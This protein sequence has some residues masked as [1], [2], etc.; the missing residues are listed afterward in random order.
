MKIEKK[1]GITHTWGTSVIT[2]MNKTRKQYPLS[3]VDTY[4]AE[5]N[6]ARL[7]QHELEILSL[8][9]QPLEDGIRISDEDWQAYFETYNNK[10]GGK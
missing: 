8:L 7:V 10:T 2:L 9:G 6:T 4:I 1:M 3:G 5:L